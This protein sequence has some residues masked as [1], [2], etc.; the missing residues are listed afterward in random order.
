M[1]LKVPRIIKNW[2]YAK[3]IIP[4]SKGFVTN[5]AGSGRR[6][7]I[8]NNP[9]YRTEAFKEFKLT[10]DLEEPIYKNFTGNHYLEGAFVHEHSDPAPEGY[11]HVRCNLMIK[12]PLVGGMP[13]IDGAE[14]A[15]EEGDLWLCLASLEKHAST[16]ISGGERV[17]FSFGALV[18]KHSV[19]KIL[20]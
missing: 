18:N 19:E 2:E 15:I 14:L 12:K 6:F 17:T 11:E 8:C 9:L 13:I 10:P 7:S 20:A 16:P 1:N 5:N 4:A 3:F